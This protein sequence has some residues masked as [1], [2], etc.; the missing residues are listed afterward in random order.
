[1]E[2]RFAQS[3]FPGSQATEKGD[4]VPLHCISAFYSTVAAT[5]VATRAAATAA[6]TSVA[7]ATT[8]ATPTTAATTSSRGSIIKD[9]RQIACQ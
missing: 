1:L 3:I 2:I 9:Q 4:L 7:A 6:A 8:A 5:A